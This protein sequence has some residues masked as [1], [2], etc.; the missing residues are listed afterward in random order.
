MATSGPGQ[1]WLMIVIKQG[2]QDT[3]N[4]DCTPICRRSLSGGFLSLVGSSLWWVPLSGGFLSLV[5]SSLWWVPLSGGFLSL[6]IFTCSTHLLLHLLTP[7]LCLFQRTVLWDI[8]LV[9]FLWPL[10]FGTPYMYLVVHH[11][12]IYYSL[13]P[14]ETKATRNGLYQNAPWR[15]QTAARSDLLSLKQKGQRKGHLLNWNCPMFS[16]LT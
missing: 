11:L 10:H 5:G 15:L 13:T 8:L 4:H 2:W 16:T 12:A 7:S 1:G 14:W 6:R 3:S 9:C